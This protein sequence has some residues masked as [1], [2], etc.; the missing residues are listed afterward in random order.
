[1]G[2][3]ALALFVIGPQAGS[4]DDDGDGSPD[5]PV[6]VSDAVVVIDVSAVTCS[7]TKSRSSY[8]LTFSAP[9]P[10][11]VPIRCLE[12]GKFELSAFG[13]GDILPARCPLR[14]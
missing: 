5:I 7:P 8:R 11:K 4:L 12:T 13:N 3:A 2:M 10:R 9:A 6:V 14:C 1:M